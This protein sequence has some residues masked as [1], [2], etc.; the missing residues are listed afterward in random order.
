[1]A[2]I[3][4]AQLQSQKLD[5][6]IEKQ[7]KLAK[8]LGIKIPAKTETTQ[9]REWLTNHSVQMSEAE[10][11]PSRTDEVVAEM[12][13]HIG[14]GSQANQSQLSSGH[15]EDEIVAE[16]LRM[17]GIKSGLSHGKSLA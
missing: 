2:P 9:Q 12:L 11:S 15:T 16:Q 3:S 14:L 13:G 1:M 4:Y 17:V 5:R 8:K 6:E 7:L 10:M